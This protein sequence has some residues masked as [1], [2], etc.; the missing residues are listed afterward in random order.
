MPAEGVS[1]EAEA[2]RMYDVEGGK[3]SS[4]PIDPTYC[5]TPIESLDV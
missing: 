4:L 3:S 1:C 5:Y 2:A